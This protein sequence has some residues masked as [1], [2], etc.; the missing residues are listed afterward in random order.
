M[1]DKEINYL[2]YD[3][4]TLANCFI[5]CFLNIQTNQRKSYVIHEDRNEGVELYGFMC[6]MSKYRWVSF[7]GLNFDSQIMHMI[8]QRRGK[9]T[10]EEIYNKTQE[11]INLPDNKRYEKLVPEWK[12]PYQEIDLYAISHFGNKARRC[13]LKHLQYAMQFPNIQEMPIHHSTKINISQLDEILE[14]CWNDVLS[15]YEYFKY[16]IGE[17]EHKEYKGVNKIEFREIIKKETGFNCLNWDD[18]KIG[19]NLNKKKYCEA[20]GIDTRDIRNIP[21]TKREVIYF[22]DCIPD[23]IEFETEQLQVFLNRLKQKSVRSTKEF[24]ESIM[25]NNTIYTFAQGGLHSKDKP[26]K[27]ESSHNIV[28]KDADVGSMYPTELIKRK[29]YP[30][31]LGEAWVNNIEDSAKAR[32]HVYKPLIKKGDKVAKSWSDGLKLGM[33]GGGYGKTNE[34]KSWQYDPLVTMSVTISGQ[35]QL[36]MLIEDLALIGIKCVSANTDGIVC[37]IPIEL[38]GK[39]SEICKAWEIQVGNIELGQLEFNNYSKLIQLSVNDYIALTDRGEIKYKGSFEIDKQLH[40]SFNFRIK[41]I[42]LEQYFIHGKDF[43]QTIMNHDSIYDFCGEVKRK[44]LYEKL[45]EDEE[46][47]AEY[48]DPSIAFHVELHNTKGEVIQQ[49]KITRYFVSKKNESLVKRYYSGPNTGTLQRVVAKQN[50]TTAN[51][52]TSTN[53]KDYPI[54]YTYYIKEVEKII[55]SIEGNANQLTLF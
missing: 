17:T 23:F 18:V 31:H 35:L 33:N 42:A 46:E 8:Y 32:L 38:Q 21:T 19:D 2:V 7:N 20:T 44:D 14:Y 36:L 3:I 10:A 49:Q 11:V 39:Y 12:L 34:Y 51:L 45:D 50:C 25:F 4:E 41:A 47:S 9:I 54:N 40:K 26:R 43:R 52:I 16:I 1:E 22:S 55:N 13:S 24:K 53:P 28:L 30:A 5:V 48:Y 15:T 27:L 37:L 6:N 29:L